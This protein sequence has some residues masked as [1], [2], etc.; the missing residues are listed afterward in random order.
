MWCGVAEPALQDTCL[1][2]GDES[3][4]IRCWDLTSVYDCLEEHH[5]L[6][7][8]G[9]WRTRSLRPKQ[10]KPVEEQLQVR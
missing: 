7:H 5:L 2:T 4:R 10:G 3:G 8:T 6:V 1:Y 9:S